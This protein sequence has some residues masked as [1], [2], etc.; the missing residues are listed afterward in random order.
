[1]PREGELEALDRRSNKGL[2]RLSRL[3][4]VYGTNGP[5]LHEADKL[6]SEE[7]WVADERQKE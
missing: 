6:T 7:S 3:C 2:H 4:Y 1:M 5:E